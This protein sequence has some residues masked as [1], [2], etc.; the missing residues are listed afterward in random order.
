[1]VDLAE[2]DSEEDSAAA[3][4]VSGAAERAEA[5]KNTDLNDRL[6]T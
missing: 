2:G 5:G 3:A 4:E 1:M 6:M